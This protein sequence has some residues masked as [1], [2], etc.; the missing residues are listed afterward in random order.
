MYWGDAGT[1]YIVVVFPTPEHCFPEGEKW[2]HSGGGVI[3]EIDA[4]TY[5]ILRKD[6]QE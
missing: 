6:V 1:S 2:Y 4:R 3:Y 5:E